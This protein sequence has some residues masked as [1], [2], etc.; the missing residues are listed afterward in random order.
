MQ[1]YSDLLFTRR[2]RKGCVESP[3]TADDKTLL[4]L[5][6]EFAALCM[7]MKYKPYFLTKKPSVY[8]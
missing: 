1:I 7:H 3:K 8:Q 5:R 2:F 4:E 6:F